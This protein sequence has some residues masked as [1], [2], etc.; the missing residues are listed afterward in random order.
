MASQ[1]I[2]NSTVR[3]KL[4]HANNKEN[5][6]LCITGYLWSPGIC[7]SPMD[8]PHRG[9]VM[10]MVFLCHDGFMYH[11][12]LHAPG[13][14][15]WWRH[16]ME[17][18][19]ALLAICAGISPVTVETPSQ[20]PVTRSFD[21]F[22]DMRLNIWLRCQRA[23]Y[24]VIVMFTSKN[25]HPWNTWRYVKQFMT[26]QTNYVIRDI[27]YSLHSCVISNYDRK[28]CGGTCTFGK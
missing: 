24:D 16:Q 6:K 2:E 17:T 3:S 18:F 9:R 4:V 11:G 20:T 12:L 14:P 19:L 25:W 5:V 28:Q 10:W 7:G 23:H 26:C 27:I 13:T 15:S 22:F 8:F 21:V 1:T